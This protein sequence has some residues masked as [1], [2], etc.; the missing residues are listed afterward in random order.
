MLGRRHCETGSG[1]CSGK[2]RRPAAQPPSPGREAESLKLP[3]RLLPHRPGPGT[4]F[5]LPGLH[6]AHPFPEALKAGQKEKPTPNLHS[7][8]QPKEAVRPDVPTRFVRPALADLPLKAGASDWFGPDSPK[9]MPAN[10]AA[11][12]SAQT[13]HKADRIRAGR[14]GRTALPGAYKAAR[15][16]SAGADSPSARFDRF[17]P[18]GSLPF[19]CRKDGIISGGTTKPAAFA[20]HPGPRTSFLYQGSLS[21]FFLSIRP[22]CSQE[23]LSVSD[24]YVS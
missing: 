12:L 7:D 16:L 21:P 19:T 23:R 22:I 2:K 17:A 11:L 20:R 24:M 6:T 4:H 8:F 10:P 13:L 15:A 14:T 3:R 5:V 18:C 1:D 9:E